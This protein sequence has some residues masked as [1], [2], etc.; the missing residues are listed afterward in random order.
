MPPSAIVTDIEGTTTPIA[1]VR[2]VLFPYARER[3]PEFLLIHADDATVR[4]A[5]AET[6]ELAPGQDP[7]AAL[8][9]WMEAD[10]KITPLKKLQGL[11]WQHGYACGDLQ[12]RLYADVAPVLRRW[13][14]AG[15]RLYVYSSGSEAAQRLLFRHAV[16]GD[17]EALFSGFFDTRV[18]GKR[19]AASYRN[20]AA[21]LGLPTVE[22]LFLSDI[23][24]ELDA[25]KTAGFLTCQ[26]VRAD[27][28]TVASTRHQIVHNFVDI[29][30][31][32]AG[33]R[34]RS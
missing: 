20:I 18:G 9:A 25:A 2:D 12:G 17:L 28:G 3:L 7:V 4:A 23:E 31:N 11:I 26:L 30:M 14:A 24:Q 21:A 32:T 10:A 29:D 8:L 27:D 34:R 22:L 16:S 6:A 5:L 15:L 19:E 33:V 1:F 13:H